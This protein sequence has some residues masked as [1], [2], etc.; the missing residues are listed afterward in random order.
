MFETYHFSKTLD[1]EVFDTWLSKGRESKIGYSYLLVIWDS[2]E[3]D[4]KPKYFENRDELIGFCHSVSPSKVMV[5]AY[6]LYS[7]SKVSFE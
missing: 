3:E 2:W 7:E 1:E 4:F 6:D 5:A